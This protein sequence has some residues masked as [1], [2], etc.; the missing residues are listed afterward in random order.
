MFE[1]FNNLFDWPRLTNEI[2]FDA[3]VYSALA[4]AGTSLFVLRFLLVAIAGV[5]GDA[6]FEGD[7][8]GDFAHGGGMQIFSLLSITAFMMG[9]GWMG[10]TARIDWGLGPTLTAFLSGGFGVALMLFAS[11]LLLGMR[12]LGREVSY[13]PKTAIGR[14]ATVYTNIPKKG[15][16]TGQIRVSVSGRSKIMPAGSVGD[17]IEAF[18]DVR[19]VDV[20]DDELMIVEKIK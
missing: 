3:V 9:A 13:D 1:L 8:E 14:T 11:A 19:V 20:R 17:A 12:R 6:D 7:A 15:T 5:D 2:G 16:G 4:I 10:F 18:T